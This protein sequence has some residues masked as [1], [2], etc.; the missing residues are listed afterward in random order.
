[1]GKET[2]GCFISKFSFFKPRIPI[3]YNMQSNLLDIDTAILTRR[4]VVRRFREK[5]GKALFELIDVNRTRLMNHLPHLLDS[6]H[7]QERA[8]FFVRQ[9]LAGWLLQET[10][11]FGIWEHDTAK[12]I[13][14]I[15]IQNVD[16]KLAYGEMD[17]FV[18][19]DFSGKGIMTEVLIA[20]IRFAFQQLNLEK[21]AIKTE[22]DNYATQRLARKAGFSR[23]GDLRSAGRKPTG[24][25][26]DLML[27]GVTRNEFNK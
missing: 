19:H 3:R 9:A 21:I 23:E 8:E 17:F 25:W 22:M 13:G 24:E 27:F 6:L 7:D 2:R 26:L 1:M 16:W 12:L 18:D 14:I 11:S 15:R 4:T 10:Y 20:V 5:E